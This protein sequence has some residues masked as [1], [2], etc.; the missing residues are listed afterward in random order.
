MSEGKKKMIS[1]LETACKWA[2]RGIDFM[3]T[4]YKTTPPLERY[5]IERRRRRMRNED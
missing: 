4:W 2:D 3:I 1:Y 5:M